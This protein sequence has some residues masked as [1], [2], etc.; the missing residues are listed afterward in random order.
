MIFVLWL[1]GDDDFVAKLA[2]F[3]VVQSLNGLVSSNLLFMGM[4]QFLLDVS[5]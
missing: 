3:L 2:G 4:K 1:A 5:P